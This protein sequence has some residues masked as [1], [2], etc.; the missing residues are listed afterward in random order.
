MQRDIVT[1]RVMIKFTQIPQ[2]SE[3]IRI[4][5]KKDTRRNGIMTSLTSTLKTSNKFFNVILF[6]IIVLI[7]FDTN[8]FVIFIFFFLNETE[9]IQTSSRH[10]KNYPHYHCSV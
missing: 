7:P 4:Y 8:Q 2:S 5:F 1:R 6:I 10:G 9:T 3:E